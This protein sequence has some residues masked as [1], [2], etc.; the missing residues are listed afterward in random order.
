MPGEQLPVG[1]IGSAGSGAKAFPD[2]RTD[3]LEDFREGLKE[4]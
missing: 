4:G 3:A 2:T 1:D